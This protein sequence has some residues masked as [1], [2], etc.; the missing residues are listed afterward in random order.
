MESING[1]KPSPVFCKIKEITNGDFNNMELY[2]HIIEQQIEKFYFSGPIMRGKNQFQ[3]YPLFFLYKVLLEIGKLTGEYKISDKE[4]Y[5]WICTSTN[6]NDY[7]NVVHSILHSRKHNNLQ[8]L[9]KID[10][11]YDRIIEVLPQ[12]DLGSGSGRPEYYALKSDYLS[13]VKSKVLMFEFIKSI[14]KD[15]IGSIPNGT[16]NKDKYKDFLTKNISLIP[17]L[18]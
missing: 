8:Q 1:Y 17:K 2:L 14:Q 13:K 18:R 3:L 15:Y 6:Y 10:T 7:K 12:F 16:I 5:Y 4:F 11:R 9:D